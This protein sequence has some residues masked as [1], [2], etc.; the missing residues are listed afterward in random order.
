MA[1]AP[2]RPL[3]LEP[4]YAAGTAQKKRKTKRK[5]KICSINEIL[6]DRCHLLKFKEWV[7]EK[8]LLWDAFTSPI[9]QQNTWFLASWEAKDKIFIKNI[10]GHL[11]LGE[12][13]QI[14]WNLL[15]SAHARDICHTIL[16]KIK[17]LLLEGLVAS[18][19]P[20]PHIARESMWSVCEPALGK[21]AWSVMPCPAAAPRQ[22][23][24]C[25]FR[26]TE[27]LTNE[28]AWEANLQGFSEK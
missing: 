2:I 18:N 25:H 20:E 6:P 4:P 12:L 3:A 13:L 17:I 11:P 27:W 10:K 7:S 9:K 28:Y 23:G 21:A 22:R 24:C 8:S 5:K 26:L 15:L 1:A 19:C 14:G 16:R